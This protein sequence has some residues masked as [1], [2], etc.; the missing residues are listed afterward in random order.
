MLELVLGV[1]I[2]LLLYKYKDLLLSY[3]P[4]LNHDKK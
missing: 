3:V 1:V 4:F 2:G